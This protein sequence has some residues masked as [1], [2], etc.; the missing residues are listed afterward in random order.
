MTSINY[1]LIFICIVQVIDFVL[2]DASLRIKH[3]TDFLFPF[4]KICFVNRLGAAF[5]D[6]FSLEI[7][8]TGTG[9][10]LSKYASQN[11]TAYILTVCF[12]LNHF[13]DRE[14]PKENSQPEP[15][16]SWVGGVKR[17]KVLAIL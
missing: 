9:E 13:F 12:G 6:G 4:D 5:L 14:F 1:R 3:S 15:L 7:H 10:M 16:A 17:P 8:P 11:S 2:K